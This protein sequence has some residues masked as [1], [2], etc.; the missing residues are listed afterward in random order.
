M[1]IYFT[2]LNTPFAA[3]CADLFAA[4]GHSVISGDALATADCIDIFI[5]SDDVHVQGDDHTIFQGIDPEIIMQSVEDNLCAP[6][7]SLEAALPA[8]DNGSLKRVCF[9]TSGAYASVNFSTQV[10]GYGYAMSKAALSQAAKICYNRLYKDGYTFRMYDPLAGDVPPN[11]AAYAAVEY[12]TRS[13]AYDPDNAQG[14]TDE[15]RFVLRDARNREWP[16]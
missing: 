13:R 3:A 5:S 9:I 14:R 15:S 7:K 1:N 12:F 11:E 8:L 4:Q 2:Q 6:I 10:S 16:W